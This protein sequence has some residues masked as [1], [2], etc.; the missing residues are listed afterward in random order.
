[1]S[2]VHCC[3]RGPAAARANGAQG[4]DEY[5]NLVLDNAEEIQTKSGDRRQIGAFSD[6]HTYTHKHM[7]LFARPLSVSRGFH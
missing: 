3:P 7:P 5:M 4:F 1:M 6:V 2:Y